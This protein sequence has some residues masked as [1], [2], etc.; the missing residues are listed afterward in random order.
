MT[1][2][3]P[4][5]NVSFEGSCLILFTGFP[6]VS[7][8]DLSTL[9]L[10]ASPGD[11]LS[12]D[13]VLGSS[14]KQINFRISGNKVKHSDQQYTDPGVKV[15]KSLQKQLLSDCDQVI[16]QKIAPLVQ[17]KEA[18]PKPVV[19]YACNFSSAFIKQVKGN[20]LKF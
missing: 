3:R 16:G 10:F 17:P 12:E 1:S 19:P 2:P 4:S 6:G 13:A 20:R 18:K 14:V 5:R 15:F 11:D 8:E 7:S 9:I